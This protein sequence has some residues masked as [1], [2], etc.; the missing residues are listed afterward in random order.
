MKNSEKSPRYLEV[1]V[2]ILDPSAFPDDVF[3]CINPPINLENENESAAFH[4]LW[5]IYENEIT[6][7]IRYS[8]VKKVIDS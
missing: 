3:S 5:N 1:S 7:T 6:L 2:K 8:P 4:T